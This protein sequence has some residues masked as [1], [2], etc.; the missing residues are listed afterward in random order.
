MIKYITTL[1][2]V[3]KRLYIK[4]IDL[5]ILGQLKGNKSMSIKMYWKSILRATLF[6]AR[7]TNL[8]K[9]EG[10][11]K[12]PNYCIN[13]DY[14]LSVF[15]YVI[16]N[17]QKCLRVRDSVRIFNLARSL[18]IDTDVLL[19]NSGN[20]DY[21][22]VRGF[23]KI[24][25]HKFQFGLWK[26][27]SSVAIRQYSLSGE[28]LVRVKLKEINI[29]INNFIKTGKKVQG[30]SDIL[31][32]PEF[33]ESCCYK[34][35]T[36]KK[37]LVS[38]PNEFTLDKAWFKSAASKV[39]KGAII[40]N[41]FDTTKKLKNQENFLIVSQPRDKIIYEALKQLLELTF[42]K[43]LNKNPCSFTL[44]K[45]YNKAFDQF[46]TQMDSSQWFI[47]GSIFNF[48]DNMDHSVLVSKLEKVIDDQSFIDL[49]HKILKSKYKKG[50]CKIHHIKIGF[51]RKNIL[52]PIL[53]DIYLHEFDLKIFRLASAFNK[54]CL[55][56]RIRYVR[57]ADTFL[58]GVIG[59]KKDCIQI[60]NKI[61]KILWIYFKLNLDLK[62][63]K[64][65][66]SS[67]NS[68]N[69]FGYNIRIPNINRCNVLHL[70]ESQKIALKLIRKPLL[71]APISK[72][73]ESLAIAG[74]CKKSGNPTRCAQ[75]IQE[76]LHKILYKYLS[77]YR[78]LLNH[79]NQSLNYNQFVAKVHY[80]LKYS[81][82]LT[83]A[84]KLKLGT[85]KKVFKKFGKNL[86]VFLD[87]EKANKITF[88]KISYKKL[89][90]T[91]IET[92]NPL[93]CIR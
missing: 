41:S 91:K 54:N 8:F 17:I 55:F 26:G 85:L 33:L 88:Y 43:I 3:I 31:K 83:F 9:Q 61:S 64:V 42:K 92:F 56:K 11:Q 21:R 7:I 47:E 6:T 87:E 35:K 1:L 23:G 79:Y 77:I 46:C 25:V 69:F 12:I 76:P 66:D 29:K 78:Q 53:S 27:L 38:E 48:Y 93:N 5:P 74:Y 40:F 51:P 28:I 39:A 75:L 59:S 16:G 4:A 57:Y 71:Y 65:L 49:I 80:I 14:K 58:I 20:P 67:K 62:K 84:S 68:A 15:F 19:K 44:S 52:A 2:S 82:A 37:F 70:K 72:I 36:A 30:L 32:I 24:V 22:K 50:L 13:S 73:I 10:G 86:T 60:R 81:C 45:N 90:R 63:I 18:R 89:K 34:T